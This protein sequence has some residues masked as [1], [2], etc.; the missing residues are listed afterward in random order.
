VVISN[1]SN[2]P[3]LSK[4]ESASRMGDKARTCGLW[5]IQELSQTERGEGGFYVS[6]VQ[7]S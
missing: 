7:A 4:T 6:T 1:L 3:L 2:V 5:M